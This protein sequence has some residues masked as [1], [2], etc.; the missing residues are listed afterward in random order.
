LVG[1]RDGID[2]ALQLFTESGLRSVFASAHND[3][4]TRARAGDQATRM[5]VETVSTRSTGKGG[6]RSY[7]GTQ[8]ILGLLSERE[9]LDYDSV[10]AGLGNAS[11]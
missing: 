6:N 2:T 4:A 8:I 10:S 11:D 9:D 1:K 5:A 3:S 7:F